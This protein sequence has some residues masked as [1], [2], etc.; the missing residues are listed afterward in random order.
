MILFGGD[1][2]L[3]TRNGEGPFNKIIEK[4]LGKAVC[5]NVETA[6]NR[7]VKKEKHISLCADEKAFYSMPKEVKI[8]TIVNNHIYDCGDPADLATILK[9]QCEVV[10]GPNNPSTSRMEYDGMKIDFFAAYFSLPRK[11]ISY[12]GVVSK[13]IFQLLRKSDADR[14]ILNLHWGY[15]HSDMPAPFQKELAHRFIDAGVS[16]IIG[17]HPHVPQGC[18]VYKG[19]SI[20]YSLGNF[21]FWQLDNEISKDNLW[22]YMVDYDPHKETATPIPYTINDN[23]Q[24]VS[25]SEKEEA[26][27]LSKID[28]L[29]D[30]ISDLSYVEWYSKEYT[31]WYKRELNVWK[32]DRAKSSSLSIYVKWI[33]WLILPMQVRYYLYMVYLY[34]KDIYRK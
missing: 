22:G 13:K 23:Y 16:L 33:V 17:H 20:F 21:N 28:K 26:H 2:F 34:F 31:P 11:N 9:E 10:V 14:K 4:F 8:S 1:T 7:G 12:N 19:K 18:E 25:L 29:S 15:E 30:T 6:L 24:P 27:Y 5:L 32:Q 3:K